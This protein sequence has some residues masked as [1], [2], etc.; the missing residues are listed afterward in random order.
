MKESLNILEANIS[1]RWDSS[2]FAWCLDCLHTAGI[3]RESA[4]VQKCINSL[5]GVQGE[6]GAWT[7]ADGEEYA[8]SNTINVLGALRQYGAL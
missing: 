7:S 2:D 8:V 6:N 3:P 4:L 5:I 1:D